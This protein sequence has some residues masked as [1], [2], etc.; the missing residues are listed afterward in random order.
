MT[1]YLVTGG[2]GFIGSHVVDRLLGQRDNTVVAYDKLSNSHLRWLSPHLADPRFRFV[3][4]DTLDLERLTKEMAGAEVVA[5]LASSV[6]MRRGLS[7]PSFDLEQCAVATQ[8]VLEAARANGVGR[9]I[10]SSSSTVY[11]DPP[12]VPTPEHAGPLQPISLYGVGKLAAEGLLSAYNHLF[13]ID[14]YAFRFGNVVGARM[15]HGI[16]Y[17]FIAK[18]RRDPARLEVLGDGAQSKNYFLV[19]DC[20]EGMLGLPERLGRGAHVV[21]LGCAGTVR[22]SRIAEIVLQEM[23][24]TGAEISYTG[25]ARGWPGDVPI[26]QFDLSKVHRLGWRASTSSEGAVRECTRRLLEGWGQP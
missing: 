4:A 26:V 9:V 20:I 3:Q 2:A 18:L 6:D 5:H 11:G 16:V 19:E 14:T 10:F 25:G 24:L 15:N 1:A 13:G 8:R 12:V 17:D 23:G 22:V 7:D 21:N